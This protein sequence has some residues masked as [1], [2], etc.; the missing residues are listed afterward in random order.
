MRPRS[1]RTSTSVQAALDAAR[2]EIER[3]RE[4][5]HRLRTERL[6]GAGIGAAVGRAA[7]VAGTAAEIED[8]RD[9]AWHKG[10]EVLV[11]QEMLLD[12]C[13]SVER[14]MI[15]VRA[16]LADGIPPTE[17]DR[18]LVDRRRSDRL[19][20]SAPSPRAIGANGDPAPNGNGH[21]GDGHAVI[22]LAERLRRASHSRPSTTHRPEGTER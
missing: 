1:R 20:T 6:R 2:I 7:G 4:D 5:N 14:A 16:Q 13:M 10:V 3:L 17:L 9:Q 19:G 8:R 12:L 18:R 22:S 11:L 21:G 15:A